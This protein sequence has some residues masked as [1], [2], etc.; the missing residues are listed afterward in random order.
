MNNLVPMK[1]IV[2]TVK[3]RLGELRGGPRERSEGISDPDAAVASVAMAHA[4]PGSALGTRLWA[5][6]RPGS[7]PGAG[8]DSGA[9]YR[10]LATARRQI[11]AWDRI[12]R[13][14]RQVT[15]ARIG[16][17]RAVADPGLPSTSGALNP[18]LL[19]QG[20]FPTPVLSVPEHGIEDDQEFAHTGH[21]GQF[22]GFAGSYQA[23]VK[24]PDHRD[25]S[26]L[27][28]ARTCTA[29]RAP[30]PCRP[31]RTFCRRICR[32]R[33]LRAQLPPG[34][35]AACCRCFPAPAGRR[36]GRRPAAGR[37]REPLRS[38]RC[39]SIARVR[40]RSGRRSCDP[41]PLSGA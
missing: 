40:T 29:P 2:L 6:L 20:L 21:Q 13:T 16:R 37:P 1:A 41:G 7:C 25:E 33:D 22:L 27:P 4:F 38:G 31:I 35:L 24:V 11:L 32:C 17:C 10:P 30:F 19:I 8:G 18:D 14:G 5:R 26:G 3:S 39:G 9:S 34:R 12:S 28:P 36:R 15:R 23:V